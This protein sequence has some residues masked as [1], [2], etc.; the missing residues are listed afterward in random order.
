MLNRVFFV[1]GPFFAAAAF[2]MAFIIAYEIYKKQKFSGKTLYKM[3]F[4]IAV[5]SFFLF[6]ILSIIISLVLGRIMK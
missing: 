3:A 1:L 5:F 4:R 6:L 2:V